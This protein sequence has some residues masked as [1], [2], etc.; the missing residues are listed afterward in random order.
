MTETEKSETTKPE[1]QQ[2]VEALK[3]AD[4]I[5]IG[6]GAGMSAAAGLDYTDTESFAERFPG[7][8]QYGFSYKYQLMGYQ[9]SDEA[10]QWGY[11]SKALDY[12]YH[13][14]PTPVYQNLLKLV[15]DKDY[16]AMTS[17]VDRYFH[18]NG[19]DQSRIF[20]PQGDYE[21]F[22]CL[23]PCTVDSF[24]DC[25]EQILAMSKS[26][27]PE[28][29]I[30]EDRSLLPTCPNCGGPVFMNVRGGAWFI[31]KPYVEQ[32]KAINEWLATTH[33]KH[34][35]LIEV[36]SGF[37]TPGVIRMPMESIV[38]HHPKASLIRI[39]RDHS[40][41]P[42]GTISIAAAADVALSQIVE[43]YDNS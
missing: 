18:K 41:G 15:K 6:A 4:C 27:N 40:A 37:N 42:K 2:A 9:F 38:S 36:G 13:A 25:K 1:I 24:W 11:Y 32:S 31:E 5:L 23:K 30:V 14:K 43:A 10:L 34:L 16:F 19:F 35:T 33:D 17:N 29:Q 21:K 39:N 22:Q 28:T 26:V 7:M 8:L 20:T 3:Q 12:V